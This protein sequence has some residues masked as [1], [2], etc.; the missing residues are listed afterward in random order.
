MTEKIYFYEVDTQS[1]N[2][3]SWVDERNYCSEVTGKVY[4]V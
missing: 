3:C 2:L 4:Y 1:Y